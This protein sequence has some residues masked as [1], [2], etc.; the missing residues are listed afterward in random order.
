MTPTDGRLYAKDSINRTTP[1][2]ENDVSL[3]GAHMSKVQMTRIIPDE[4]PETIQTRNHQQRDL[5][6]PVTPTTQSCNARLGAGPK[7]R[8]AS[9]DSPS[10]ELASSTQSSTRK[11]VTISDQYQYYDE[12]G[13]RS[14]RP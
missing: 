12:F 2:D 10:N 11:G 14:S 13:Q 5:D 6:G 7:S 1:S 9:E 4:T 3:L 8:H